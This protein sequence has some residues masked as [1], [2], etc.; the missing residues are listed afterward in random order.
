MEYHSYLPSSPLTRRQVLQTGVAA[1]LPTA[2]CLTDRSG[3]ATTEPSPTHTMDSSP[4]G[5]QPTLS[6]DALSFDVQLMEEFT[7]EHPARIRAVLT[8]ESSS[9]MTFFMGTTPPFTEY[10]SDGGQLILIPELSKSLPGKS[11][12]A[13]QDGTDEAIPTTPTDGCWRISQ[14]VL[15]QQVGMYVEIGPEESLARSYDV[16]AYRSSECYPPGT[17]RFAHEAELQRGEN[18]GSTEV[19]SYDV[20]LGFDLVVHE[21]KSLSVEVYETEVSPHVH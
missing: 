10:F 16:Y 2:G 21:D 17:Y 13:W 8:N 11:P 19:P 7:E 3:Q 15:I 9:T 20:T 12:F 4:T 6:E 5:P 1:G 14:R 18:A